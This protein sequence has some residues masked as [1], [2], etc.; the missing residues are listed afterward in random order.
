MQTQSRKIAYY[1]LGRLR[2]PD[3]LPGIVAT[4]LLLFGF[5][6]V[7]QSQQ[8]AE[9][10]TEEVADGRY[11]L[12]GRGGNI[13]ASLGDQGVMIVDSQFPDMVPKYQSTIRALGGGEVDFTINTHWHY[14]H[15]DGNE[16][17]GEAG[18]W[19]VAHRHSREMMMQHNTINTVT[20]PIVEQAPY[21]TA[22]LPVTTFDTRMEMYFNGEQVDL[23]H[24]GPAHTRGDAAVYFRD[25]NVIHMG[26]VYNN[27]GYP[28]IDA[29]NGGGIEGVIAFCEAIL[30]EINTD[31]VVVPGHGPVA[32]Y[33]DLAEYVTML[34]EIR[35]KMM[36]LIGQGA[37]LE[38][39]MAA[40]VT[41]NWDA[42]KGDPT[43]LVNR[44]YYSLTR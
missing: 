36:V 29:E 14:D 10:R 12:F 39:V 26:D 3:Y 38:E 16:L 24:A 2:V 31:T 37:S 11:V 1:Q 41:A 21:A 43:R 35:G 13:L 4:I 44:A 42:K 18:S 32:G 15:A 28:F 9:I 30:Q 5:P 7:V 40:N 8:S 23:I 22:G 6:F 20:N 27:A 34:T 17:L 19:I 25:S 33:A